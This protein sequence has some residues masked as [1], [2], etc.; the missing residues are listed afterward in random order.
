MAKAMVMDAPQKLT[1]GEFPERPLRDGEML[2]R[3]LMTGVC[4]TDKHLFLG[5]GAWNFPL[6]PGHEIVGEVVEV[7]DGAF[8]AITV[9][10]GELKIGQRVVLVPSSAP[11]GRCF[12]CLNYPH[13]T[14]LC[15]KRFVYGFRRCDEPPHL[16][17]G[18]AEF[19]RVQP[20]SFLFV[21]PEDLPDERAVLTEPMAV[22]MRAVERALAPGIPLIGE[23][24]GIGR[25]ALVIGVGPIGLLV[26][27]TLKGMG[28]H[29]IIAADTMA[30]RLEV[31]QKLGAT[32]T[33]SV[34]PDGMDATIQKIRDLTDGEGA[35]VVFE[36]AGVPTA[37]LM[38]LESVCRGGT[39]IEVGHFTDSGT[40][41]LAPHLICR[42]DL[43]VRGVWAYPWWQFRDALRFLHTTALPLETLITHRLFLSQVS[44][45]LSG[46]LGQE[47]IKSVVVP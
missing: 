34:H 23:G 40:I 36:C 43:D 35:D 39:V 6:I 41:A 3:V 14:T 2:L 28:V 30:M 17:G 10:G 25:T 19:I 27:A 44:D 7:T 32:E 8:D 1:M 33:V 37:F 21:V 31:A 5:H 18:F 4:G 38:A 13:R 20:R 16:F 29:S 12:Y 26:V 46:R 42:K 47:A 11:C 15:S 45:A 9:F 24:L 22:A